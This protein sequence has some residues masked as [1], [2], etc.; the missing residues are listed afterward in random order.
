MC[1]WAAP[2]STQGGFHTSCQE[3]CLDTHNPGKRHLTA[4]SRGRSPREHAPAPET[5]PGVTQTSLPLQLRHAPQE[6]ERR[7][8]E[9]PVPTFSLAVSPPPH[10]PPRGWGGAGELGEAAVPAP[11]WWCPAW[12]RAAARPAHGPLG[13]ARPETQVVLTAIYRR[14]S[15][16]SP[17]WGPQSLSDRETQM[18]FLGD[19]KRNSLRSSDVISLGRK[20][21]IVRGQTGVRVWPIALKPCP[22]VLGGRRE[23]KIL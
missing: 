5:A 10:L 14:V 18:P 6:A 20:K 23:L 11:R 3:P 2:L 22:E 1:M 7:E 4:A 21:S 17:P 8:H 12:P 9:R 13:Q 16:C 19:R 15:L